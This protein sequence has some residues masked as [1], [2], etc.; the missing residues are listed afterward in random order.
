MFLWWRVHD[1]P[2]ILS[3][4]CYARVPQKLA[5]LWDRYFKDRYMCAH[6]GVISYKEYWDLI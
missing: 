4:Q 6:E 2:Q 5:P 1:Y 3:I